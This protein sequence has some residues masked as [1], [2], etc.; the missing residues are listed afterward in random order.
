MLLSLTKQM[1]LELAQSNI[2]VVCGSDELG[3]SRR[4]R[5]L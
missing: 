1:A 5:F 3:M 4:F 2:R